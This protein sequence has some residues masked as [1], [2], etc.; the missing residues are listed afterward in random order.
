MYVN[1]SASESNPLINNILFNFAKAT[2]LTDSNVSI[3]GSVLAPN[4][5]LQFGYNHVNG[6]LIGASLSGFVEVHNYPFNGTLPPP[7]KRF[8][9][10]RGSS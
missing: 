7:P 10:L 1:G 8:P 5:A 6:S 4:A 3:Y 9:S 2:S